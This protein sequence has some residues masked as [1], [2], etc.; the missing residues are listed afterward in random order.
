MDTGEVVT[1]LVIPAIHKEFI[2]NLT[3]TLETES[4]KETL[5]R[6]QFYDYTQHIL[7]YTLYNQEFL[8]YNCKMPT[9]KLENTIGLK[10]Y[11]LKHSKDLCY[12]LENPN[13]NLKL[14]LLKLRL[15]HIREQT[16]EIHEIYKNICKFLTNPQNSLKFL[17]FLPNSGDL[18]CIALGFFYRKYQ[19]MKIRLQNF[20]EN[21]KSP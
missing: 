13:K 3:K 7:D 19:S 14:N 4:L 11:I 21:R 5:L 18:H 17:A 15:S 1:S 8:T 12:E 20:K 10:Y 16:N 9:E 2:K 6:S